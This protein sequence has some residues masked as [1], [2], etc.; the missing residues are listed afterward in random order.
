MEIIYSIVFAIAILVSVFEVSS[1]FV[2]GALIKKEYLDKYFAAHIDEYKEGHKSG[3][4]LHGMFCSPYIS[5]GGGILAKYYVSN[6]GR[7]PRWSKWTKV[8]DEI[9]WDI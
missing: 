8:L 9:V 4:I 6:L 1:R 7:I 3:H 5:T 2:Y